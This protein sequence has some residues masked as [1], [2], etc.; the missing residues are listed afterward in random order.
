MS[1]LLLIGANGQLGYFLHRT[2]IGLGDVIATTRS[3]RLPGSNAA[4]ESA[5]IE[6][7]DALGR[8]IKRIAPDIVINAAAYT[9]VD[10]AESDPQSAYRTNAEAVAALARACRVADA[11]LIHYST[12]Y[13]FSG[14]SNRP[15]REDDRCEPV[16]VYGASKLA[17]EVAIRD[18]S[19]RHMIFRTAWV[20]GHRGRNFLRSMLKHGS[21]GDSVRVVAD[22][23]GSPTPA[24]WIAQATALILARHNNPSGTWHLTAAG[25]SSWHGFAEAIF[26]DALRAGLIEKHPRVD[27]ISSI[28]YPGAA[29]RPNYSRL[30][31]GKVL[32][33]FGIA[34]P[35]WRQGVTRVVA[36]LAT[37]REE[38]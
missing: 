31:N 9:A 1:R 36:D 8:L 15:W 10:R 37:A 27:A 5:D 13:V 2:L 14:S 7:S 35:H 29:R 16:S 32:A 12:D 25:E 30:D 21:A 24:P 17:G 22:Q 34:L 3:G 19:C 20:Y 26:E 38:G 18:S 28:E 4:C 6:Q 11:L 23:V 33:D